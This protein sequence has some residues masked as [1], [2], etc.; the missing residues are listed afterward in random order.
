MGLKQCRHFTRLWKS[1][2]RA[3]G[4]DQLIIELDFEYAP[5]SLD[6]LRVDVVFICDFS[7]QTGGSGF[8]VS[9]H[10]VFD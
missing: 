3:F 7:R 8:V 1:A 4:E 10:A 9:N 5:R 6:Q 2:F